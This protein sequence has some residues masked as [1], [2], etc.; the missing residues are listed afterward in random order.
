M[1]LSYDGLTD[2]SDLTS[3]E[4]ISFRQEALKFEVQRERCAGTWKITQ[5]SVELMGGSCTG[6]K[7]SQDIVQTNIPY[8]MDVLPVM[9][10][11]L[12]SYS[13]PESRSGSPWKMPSFTTAV[14]SMYWARITYMNPYNGTNFKT[15]PSILYTVPDEKITSTRVTMQN[16]WGLYM[17]LVV[18]PVLTVIMLALTILLYHTPISDGFG[19][20]S[21]L[22]GIER[23]SLDRLQGAALSG[24]LI[25]PVSMHIS[26]LK[27]IQTEGYRRI[28]YS[29]ADVYQK[30]SILERKEKYG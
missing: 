6:E 29:L 16:E 11:W 1:G 10:Q 13:P 22:A 21:V 5:S 19:L 23:D 17:I 8:F 9:A 20:V 12:I 14:S 3:P 25:K 2:T 30:P 18:H 24:N 26:V 28:Q 4:S 27:K 7:V 15:H